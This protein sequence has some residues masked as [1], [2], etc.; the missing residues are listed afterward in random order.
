MGFAFI[1][2]ST[3]IAVN[4]FLAAMA[5]WFAFRF[6]SMKT[7]IRV[8]WGS[9]G[10][11]ALLLLPYLVPLEKVSSIT[12]HYFVFVVLFLAEIWFYNRIFGA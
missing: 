12:P 10:L 5:F 1:T 2:W 4:A 6:R 9:T 8:I 7:S 3:M 11:T